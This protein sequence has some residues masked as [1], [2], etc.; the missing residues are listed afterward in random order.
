MLHIGARV[1]YDYTHSGKT[2][3]EHLEYLKQARHRPF[4]GIIMEYREG[5][6]GEWGVVWQGPQS[7]GEVSYWQTSALILVTPLVDPIEDELKELM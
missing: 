3:H 4:Y 7:S 1:L 6:Y 5:L 2:E